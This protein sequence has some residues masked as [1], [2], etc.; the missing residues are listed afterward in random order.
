MTNAKRGAAD[1]GS[2]DDNERWMVI[3]GR[4]W[5]RTDPELPEELVERLKSH[6][7]RG[8]SGVGVAKRA[9]DDSAVAAS[10]KRVGIAKHG[11]GERGPYWWEEPVAARIQRAHDALQELDQ[12]D[13][14]TDSDA[15]AD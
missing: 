4:R 6:L 5:R 8:R 14:R 3:N 9:N 1:D 11:L 2:A 7:G 15:D 12:L 10:R 13:A